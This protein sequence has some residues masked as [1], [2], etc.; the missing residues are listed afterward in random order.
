MGHG[1]ILLHRPEMLGE[2]NLLVRDKGD[3]LRFQST[4]LFSPSTKRVVGGD[5][6]AF[7]DDPM[8]RNVGI[9]ITMEGKTDFSGIVDADGAGNIAIGENFARGNLRNKM[10]D[11]GK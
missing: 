7:F 3:A 4:G 5:K 6:T 10:A 8:T 1:S 11:F 9:L 2:V